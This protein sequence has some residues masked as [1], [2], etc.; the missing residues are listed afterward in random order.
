MLLQFVTGLSHAQI[1]THDQN[2]LPESQLSQLNQLV[3][4]RE[5]GEP[6]AYILGKR[7]FYGREFVVSPDVL[8]P[9]P[10]T[11]HLLEVAIF[12]LPENGKLWDLGTGSGILAISA[13]LERPD[14]TVFASD[15]SPN[16][17]KVAQQNAA[18]WH[19]EITFGLGS[20]TVVENFRLPEN[21]FDVLVSNPPYIKKNDAHLSRG[22]LRFEPQHALTDFTDGLAHIRQLAHEARSCL[23]NG[24]WLLMEHGFDQAA[25][26]REILAQSGYAN[27]AT[28]QDWAGLDRVTF[29]QIQAA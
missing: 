28:E 22:D 23:K 24:G 12:R 14:A 4:R 13:K 19:A 11:E 6:M 29:G 9:R 10:E 1:I 2:L 8:I 3:S 15:I 26:V 17:L 21:S 25:A 7:E 5:N 20:W 27:I 18:N 16:A